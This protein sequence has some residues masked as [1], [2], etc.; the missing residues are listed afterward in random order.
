ME[1]NSKLLEGYF[2]KEPE[3]KEKYIFL[4][5]NTDLVL[6]IIE[7]GFKA[8]AIDSKEAADKFIETIAN[9]TGKSVDKYIFVLSNKYDVF[10]PVKEELEASGLKTT[11]DGFKL[12]HGKETAYALRDDITE[13]KEALDGY[14]RGLECITPYG[15]E[16]TNGKIKLTDLDYALFAKYLIEKYTIVKIGEHLHR[17]KNG[18]Y[19]YLTDNEF[20]KVVIEEVYNSKT[21][22]RAEFYKYVECY[23][24]QKEQSNK[25]YILFNNGVYDIEQGQLLPI[26]PDFVFCNRIPHNYNPN[27]AKSDIFEDFIQS[28]V[29]Y[30]Q[31][32]E[33]LLKEV[34]G[35]CFYRS[36][37]LQVFLFI[38]GGGGNGKS[39]FSE[40]MQ[41]LLGA[42]NV[43][44]L[45]LDEMKNEFNLPQLQGKLLNIGDDIEDEYV[46]KVGV[47]KKIVSGEAFQ[48][49]GKFKDK[50]PMR[51]YGKTI[52]TGN[53]LPKMND[54]TNGLKRRMTIL[55]FLNYFKNNPDVDLP[56]KLR[57]EEVAEY[58]IKVGLEG[59]HNVIS[60]RGFTLPKISQEAIK[61]YNEKNNHVLEFI[62]E[63]ENIILSKETKTVY[64]F[65]YIEFCKD[66]GYKHVGR[67][68]FYELLSNEGYKKV[69]LDDIPGR[70]W[71]FKK[72]KS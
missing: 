54:K 20:D 55:P 33:R 30:D 46:E 48:A 9:S 38:E 17:Y 50:K 26:S 24:E 44:L 39:T 15:F 7:C 3:G 1:L 32:A 67:N 41:Y 42:E 47:L 53:S 59:L 65:Y 21:R 16:M 52:F 19:V 14:I 2:D 56:D 70:P 37:F 34:I 11:P 10:A 22:D 40:F 27:A 35:Y 5:K 62:E 31:E 61:K 63:Y 8:W 25:R 58:A 18:L 28:I 4:V 12:F 45:T 57:Q 72:Y 23:A 71:V 36:N 60:K 6:K 13:L 69:Q 64:S 29:K 49:G 43:S 68:T 66:C 51:F